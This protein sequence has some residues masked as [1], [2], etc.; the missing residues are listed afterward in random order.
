VFVDVD[1][2]FGLV[3]DVFDGHL[4]SRFSAFYFLVLGGKNFCVVGWGVG[5]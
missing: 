3:W 1:G 4:V 5:V 2:L